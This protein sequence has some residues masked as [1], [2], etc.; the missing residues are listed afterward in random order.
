MIKPQP[1]QS[2]TSAART[3]QS[4]AMQEFGLA[5]EPLRSVSL[6]GGVAADWKVRAPELRSPWMCQEILENCE[7]SL[8]MM[9]GLAGFPRFQ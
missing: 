5:L 1:A 9:F 3:F 8:L 7:R 6:A 2:R 4:A